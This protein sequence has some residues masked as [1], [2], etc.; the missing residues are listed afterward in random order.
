[1][2]MLDEHFHLYFQHFQ[3]GIEE[4]RP[5]KELYLDVMPPSALLAFSEV[6]LLPFENVFEG[7]VTHLR[8]NIHDYIF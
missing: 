4:W 8:I 3:M 6:H 5:L 7:R 1:M 2:Y